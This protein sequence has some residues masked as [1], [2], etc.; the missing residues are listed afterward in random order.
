MELIKDFI[1]LTTTDG[2]IILD[3]HA[4]SGTTAHAVLDLNK[5]GGSRKFILIEQMDYIEDI[6]VQRI[7]KAMKKYDLNESFVCFELKKY[8]QYF[9]DKILQAQTMGDLDTVY[10]DMA[11]NAFFKFWFDKDD[12]Q[13]QYKK[14]A[15]DKQISLDDRKKILIEVL[16]ENQL[17]LNYADIDDTRFNVSDDDK[18]LSKAFYGA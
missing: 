17:Y 18:A 14:D 7:I 10:N 8:N 1:T 6:T 3:Y 16:D 11:K 15:D 13:K 4:G 2:D 9:I 5:N 12:F